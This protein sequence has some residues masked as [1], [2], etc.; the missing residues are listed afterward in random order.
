LWP[1]FIGGPDEEAAKYGIVSGRRVL[2]DLMKLR[3]ER[4]MAGTHSMNVSLG[5]FDLAV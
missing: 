3:G 1:D 5:P 4:S 2:P